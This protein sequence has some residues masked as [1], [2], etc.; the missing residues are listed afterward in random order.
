MT[1]FLGSG[2]I[3]G[4]G[5]NYQQE[6]KVKSIALTWKFLE[7][8]QRAISANLKRQLVGA[9]RT[10]PEGRRCPK[11]L[12]SQFVVWTCHLQGVTSIAE[13]CRVSWQIATSSFIR[14]CFEL[15]SSS[16]EAQPILHF[17]CLESP[18]AFAGKRALLKVK[19]VPPSAASHSVCWT[20]LSVAGPHFDAAC[21]NSSD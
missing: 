8:S 17:N 18:I 13:I 2:C 11:P 10:H 1:I 20:K 5:K 3:L 6:I 9:G 14:V 12:P 4:T 19:D 21:S 7:F 15:F 16:S